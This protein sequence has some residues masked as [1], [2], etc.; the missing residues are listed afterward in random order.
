MTGKTVEQPRTLR[1]IAAGFEGGV[2]LWSKIAVPGL[3]ELYESYLRDLTDRPITLLEL[4]VYTGRSLKTFAS[5]FPKGKIIGID[6]EDDE[7]DFAGFPNVVFARGDQ[8]KADELDAICATHAP[9]GL[10]VS[11]DD[12]SHYGTWSLASYTALFPHLKPGGLYFIEDWTTGYWDDW[13]DGSRLQTLVG[14]SVAEPPARRIPSHDFG[15][16]GFIKYLVEEVA[17]GA[18]RPVMTV[19]DHRPLRMETMHVYKQVA[20]LRKARADDDPRRDWSL[21]DESTQAGH[22]EPPGS[23]DAHV[24]AHAAQVARL[25]AELGRL[26]KEAERNRALASAVLAARNEELDAIKNSTSWRITGPVRLAGNALAL[27]TR[28]LGRA[29]RRPPRR[30]E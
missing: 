9:D 15:M 14:E 24:S 6:I 29:L 22:G 13:P 2:K 26:A 1:E 17:S 27:L 18:I 19:H 4:G 10:D 5:Y 3:Y 21:A 20:V 8:R 30:N 11:I 12:A 28:P 25:R 7:L 23:S 16:V